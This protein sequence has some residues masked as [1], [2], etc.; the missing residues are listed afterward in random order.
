MVCRNRVIVL[1]IAL[2]CGAQVVAGAKE[3]E[4]RAAAC[5]ANIESLRL[6]AKEVGLSADGRVTRTALSAAI[7]RLRGGVDPAVIA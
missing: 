5:F 6:L 3:V 2:G 4:Q 1:T 7:G